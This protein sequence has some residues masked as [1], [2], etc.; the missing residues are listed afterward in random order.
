MILKA[1]KHALVLTRF[2]FDFIYFLT[3]KYTDLP[4]SGVEISAIAVKARAVT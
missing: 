4:I 3:S 2:E 1:A